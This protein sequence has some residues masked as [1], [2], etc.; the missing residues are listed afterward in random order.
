M[1]K[2][3]LK[4]G[5]LL[6]SLVLTVGL[7]AGCGS[8]SQTVAR[9]ELV[10]EEQIESNIASDALESAT[11][12]DSPTA[13][14]SGDSSEKNSTTSS[15]KVNVNSRVISSASGNTSSL[16]TSTNNKGSVTNGTYPPIAKDVMPIGA[17]V[18]PPKANISR[19]NNPSFITDAQYKML[20]ESGINMIYGLYELATGDMDDIL[21]SLD[22]CQKYGIKYLIRDP[23]LLDADEDTM[24]KS[25]ERYASHPA[26]AGV[27]V[28]D[29]PGT[30]MFDTFGE[31]HPIFKK[32]LPDKYFYINLLPSYATPSQ[33]QFGA[34][35]TRTD[36]TM[37]FTRYLDE[38]IAK[39][40][41]QFLS[42]DTYSIHGPKGTVDQ[43][44]YKD[45]ST[46][47][48]LSLKHNIP[49]WVFIQCCG[50]GSMRRPNEAEI[51]WQ[52]NTCL[53]YGAKGIQY[54]C[55]FTPLEDPSAFPGNFID[56][57]GN[58]TEIYA[59]GQKANKQIAAVDHVLM[60]CTSKGIIVTGE[61]I[62]KSLPASDTVTKYG[63]LSSVTGTGSGFIT[64]CFD[65]KGKDAFYVANN[66]LL[67]NGDVTLHFSK[68]VSGTHVY[69]ASSKKFSGSSLTVS[70]KAGEG[71]L[72]Y[73][74]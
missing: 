32:L 49:F 39:V 13:S 54:F 21:K 11:S 34:A 56:K 57:D 42:Y 6:M 26:F 22:L 8:S 53:A 73:L 20:Q 18:A 59:Y 5:A 1:K 14:V 66:S 12:S 72:I 2:M 23:N 62:D 46:Y 28:Q 61:N 29:E 63:N 24:R 71:V 30:S 10:S 60:N 19:R 27:K 47:R 9:R 33:W 3:G 37:T 16:G 51:L 31:M 67:N 38:Y 70:L 64:G 55:Y 44:H 68:S 40:K 35:S 7:I 25:L 45:L 69:N 48:S 74:D 15:S 50:F 43:V 65:Y 58:K 17:W 41:P 4:L 36:G 52:V